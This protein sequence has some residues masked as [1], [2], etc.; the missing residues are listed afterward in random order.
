[1]IETCGEGHCVTCSD[2]GEPMRV[3]ESGSDGLAVCAADDGAQTTVMIDL[4]GPVALGDEL[5]VHAGTAIARLQ[6]RAA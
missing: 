3:V 4:V 6:E 2:E 1:V 5:L